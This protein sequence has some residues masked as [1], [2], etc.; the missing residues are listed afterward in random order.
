VATLVQGRRQL[1][2]ISCAAVSGYPS[3]IAFSGITALH[4]RRSLKLLYWLLQFAG[5]GLTIVYLSWHFH[6]T[7]RVAIPEPSF[8]S[9]LI[10]LCICAP[11]TKGLSIIAGHFLVG[12]HFWQVNLR[13]PRVLLYYFL[14]L[15]C[16]ALTLSFVWKYL[17][18]WLFTDAG[19]PIVM[20]L[21]PYAFIN[22]VILSWYTP[23]PARKVSATPAAG[24]DTSETSFILGLRLWY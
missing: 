17:L 24:K 1:L 6:V 12:S 5:L 13:I 10:L 7:D 8:V 11:V 3:T 21:F 2:T 19:F 22:G 15:A 4:G 9:V 23:R 18:G 20:T 16:S 14:D